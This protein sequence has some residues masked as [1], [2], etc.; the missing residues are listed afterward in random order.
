MTLAPVVPAVW[1]RERRRLPP[2]SDDEWLPPTLIRE[3]RDEATRRRSRAHR[4]A[5]DV[6]QDRRRLEKDALAQLTTQLGRLKREIQQALIGASDFRRFQAEGLLRAI[7]EILAKANRDLARGAFEDYRRAFA[8]G[9][10]HVD[11]ALQGAQ[12]LV[13][14]PATLDL[15]LVMQAFANTADLVSEPMQVF[16]NR[17][18]M[19]IRRLTAAGASFADEMLALARDLDQ[20][21]FSAV[22]YRAERIL[23]TELGRTFNAATFDRLQ[24][25]AE[26]MPFLRK[27]WI[28][29]N[30]GRTRPTHVDA[31]QR[32]V[33]GRGI[34]IA[35]RFRVGRARLRFPIDPL[36]EPAG[37][38]AAGETIMCRCNGAVDFDLDA[39]RQTPPQ[40][41]TVGQP[42]VVT[43]PPLPA[44]TFPKPKRPRRRRPLVT[45]SP[46]EAL[47]VRD[48]ERLASD[49]TLAELLREARAALEAVARIHQVP[50]SLRL[51]LEFREAQQAAGTFWSD[52]ETG[53]AL[54]IEI[55]PSVMEDVGRFVLTHEFGHYLDHSGFR[56]PRPGTGLASEDQASLPRGARGLMARLMRTIHR[57]AA[58]KQ[59]QRLAD[60][61]VVEV[62]RRT[63]TGDVVTV[64]VQVDQARIRFYLLRPRELFARAYAQYIATQSGDPVLRGGLDR[65]RM[66]TLPWQWEDR[67]FEP[68]A[69]AFTR[70]LEGVGWR[71]PRPTSPAATRAA[72][73]GTPHG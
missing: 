36:A 55:S 34:P 51:P 64:R 15:T 44:M 70:L 6:R 26:Q 46:T 21:G 57:S 73:R 1:C 22:E 25:L 13:H 11:R 10:E 52:G 53:R 72:P 49:R 35:E 4:A 20:A 48:A 63:Q 8:L 33:R 67:D 65:Y 38:I 56:T 41:S 43:T 61:G 24:R 32:Y 27:I 19:Q 14:T 71:A 69:E 29:T 62:E 9:A 60:Q 40:R 12:I 28:A 66:S 58:V 17:I 37:R 23:R 5:Q 45:K 7:D 39:L 2:I 16:R 47:F 31:G 54:R 3:A 18:A 68:I 50:E 30:D 42:A 59:L